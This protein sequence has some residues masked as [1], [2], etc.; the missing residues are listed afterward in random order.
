MDFDLYISQSRSFILREAVDPEIC[1]V[2]FFLNIKVV[3]SIKGML[4]K[5]PKKLGSRCTK[6][7]G[8]WIEAECNVYYRLVSFC[9]YKTLQAKDSRVGKGAKN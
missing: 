8:T 7:R 4:D 5:E 1:F 9:Q 6:Y 3:R 2:Y